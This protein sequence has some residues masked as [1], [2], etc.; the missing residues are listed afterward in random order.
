M[1]TAEVEY[2]ESRVVVDGGPK[3]SGFQAYSRRREVV[4]RYL[5]G[6]IY[7]LA[8]VAWP[9]SVS[10][11]A[12]QEGATPEPDHE[13]PVSSPAP[14]TE[15]PKLRAPTPDI[16]TLSQRA[17]EHYEIKRAQPCSKKR[18]KRQGVLARL[19]RWSFV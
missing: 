1:T 15:A 7:V 11:Q 18:K 16:E 9:P 6:L 19:S 2:F 17:I 12:G 14:G 5:V 10:A 8:F 4:M 13:E 3:T